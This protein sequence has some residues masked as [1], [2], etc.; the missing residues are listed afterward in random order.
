MQARFGGEM[1]EIRM[2]S[3]LSRSDADR[4]RQLRCARSSWSWS[5]LG[6]AGDSGE[7]SNCSDA[8]ADRRELTRYG[9][10]EA[11][12][13]TVGSTPSANYYEWARQSGAPEILYKKV[14][15]IAGL[16]TEEF[17]GEV[18]RERGLNLTLLRGLVG[19]HSEEYCRLFEDDGRC[20]FVVEKPHCFDDDDDD[21]GNDD[22]LPFGLAGR[23]L[24]YTGEV[25]RR[26]R[27]H[28][29]GEVADAQV[30]GD[31]GGGALVCQWHYGRPVT[32]EEVERGAAAATCGRRGPSSV[33]FTFL[34]ISF[35]LR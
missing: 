27:P 8:L 23:C 22:H 12:T 10:E 21:D 25:D 26:F 18:S 1:N 13:Y 11:H 14:A 30:V 31:G 15:P 24:S 4:L 5:A 2:V 28:G 19:A 20:D 6:F 7:A 29:G 16:F 9:L 34:L 35:K 33:V 3:S 32:C 17:M